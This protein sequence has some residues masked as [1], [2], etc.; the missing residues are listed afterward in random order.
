MYAKL[1]VLIWMTAASCVAFTGACDSR[2]ER[3]SPDVPETAAH[4]S[5]KPILHPAA[6]RVHAMAVLAPS[7]ESEVRGRILFDQN[8]EDRIRIT[9]QV[10]GLGPGK[11]GFH[12][13]EFGDCSASDASSAGGHFAPDN[14]KHGAA[15]DP[16]ARRHAGDLGNIVADADGVAEIGLYRTDLKFDGEESFLGRAVIVHKDADDLESQPSG[17]AGARVACG[18]I[19]EIFE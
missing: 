13:H 11:H 15:S 10:Q 17:D 3:E 4:D 9:G 14:D 6:S 19:M 18:E 7:N 5:E 12:I 1:K 16:S 2:I 8:A